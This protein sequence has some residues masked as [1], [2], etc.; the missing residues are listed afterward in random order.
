MEKL[1]P[2]MDGVRFGHGVG[3]KKRK[4]IV[5]KAVENKFKTFNARVSV[6]ADKS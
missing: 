1:D 3:T 2:K 5:F 4:E 6:I